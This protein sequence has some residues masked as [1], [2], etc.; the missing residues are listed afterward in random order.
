MLRYLFAILV[1][2]VLFMLCVVGN[3]H[4]ADAA[5]DDAQPASTVDADEDAALLVAG[6]AATQPAPTPPA[7]QVS[8]II[9]LFKEKQWK[10]AIGALLMFLVF[11]WRKLDPFIAP[12]IPPKFLPF[13]VALVGFVASIPG[14]LAVTPWSWGTFI[15]N[16]LLISGTA[17]L[18]WGTVGKLLLGKF[19]PDK[20]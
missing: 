6:D 13:V 11:I 20:P 5:V 10:A 3:V 16:G 9:K 15:I 8:S 2:C 1:L 7:E 4:G 19:L 12:K 14:T 18:F 17:V